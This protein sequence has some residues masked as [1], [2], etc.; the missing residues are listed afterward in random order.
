[1]NPNDHALFLLMTDPV[2][3]Q[4]TKNKLTL[5]HD[6]ALYHAR[7]GIRLIRN[8]AKNSFNAQMIADDRPQLYVRLSDNGS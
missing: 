4:S 1:M 7:V 6:Y 3:G 2:V 5:M 8:G